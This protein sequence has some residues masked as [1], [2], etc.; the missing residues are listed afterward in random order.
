MVV[1]MMVATPIFAADMKVAFVDLQKALMECDAGLAAKGSMGQRVKEFQTTAQQRQQTLKNLNQ[2]LE[3]KKLML[4]ATARAEKEQDYQQKTKDFQR[5]IKDAQEE[6]QQEE[7]RLGRNI[8]EGL[9]KVIK[10]LG[11][12]D[13]YT[14]VLERSN[15]ALLYA[16]DSIDLTDKVIAAYNKAYKSSNGK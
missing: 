6:L 16:D 1:L 4:S 15:G 5:F 13:G 7:A 9:S 2:E 10:D 12:K 8:L 14:L 11:D 3:K